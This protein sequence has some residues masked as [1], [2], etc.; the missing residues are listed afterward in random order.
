M[1]AASR[2]K[3]ASGAEAERGVPLPR[4]HHG[5]NPELARGGDG[6]GGVEDRARLVDR[7]RPRCR[8]YDQLVP[9]DGV[10]RWA[11]TPEATPSP[12]GHGDVVRRPEPAVADVRGKEAVVERVEL[13]VVPPVFPR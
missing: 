1:V 8:G 3:G 9:A 11:L 13:A 10:R 12:A 4:N 6:G 7:G 2:A 5:G